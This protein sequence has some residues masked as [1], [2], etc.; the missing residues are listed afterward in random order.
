MNKSSQSSLDPSV[1]F[2]RINLWTMPVA[3]KDESL[4]PDQ[5]LQEVYQRHPKPVHFKP[6]HRAQLCA[7]HSRGAEDPKER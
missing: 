6:F 7:E 1:Y 4:V 3:R 2:Y 5:F